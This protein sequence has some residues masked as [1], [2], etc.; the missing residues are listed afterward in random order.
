MNKVIQVDGR[1]PN[2][3]TE[4]VASLLEEGWVILDK[5]IVGDRYITY[6]LAEPKTGTPT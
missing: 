4:E 2:Y 1:F 5:T 6:L 3:K